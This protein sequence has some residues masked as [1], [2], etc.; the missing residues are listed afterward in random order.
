MHAVISPSQLSGK[1]RVPPSKSASHRALICAALADGTSRIHN[2][3]QSKDILATVQAMKA[4]GAEFEFNGDSVVVTGIGG[5]TNVKNA[6]IY[7]NESGSTLRFIIPICCALGINAQYFGKGKL[8]SRPITPYLTEFV[9]HGVSFDYQGTMPFRTSGRLFGGKFYID[10]GISSQFITGLLL[11]LPLVNGE[12]EIHINGRL[13]SKPY[14]DI[15]IDVLKQFSIKVFQTEYGYKVSGGQRFKPCDFTVEADFSQAAFF[16]VASAL[17]GNKIECTGLNL[18]SVQGDK[19]II[20]ILRSCGAEIKADNSS[21]SV[22][23]DTLSPF[24]VSAADIPDLVPALCVLGA[25]CRGKSEISDIERLRIKESDR[26]ASS[27]ALVNSLGGKAYEQSG[28]IIIE[29]NGEKLSG[30]TI[31]SFNDHRIA[32]A[33][34][35]AACICRSD[36]II[37]NCE[38]VNKSY[39]CFYEDYNKIGGKANVVSM[40]Q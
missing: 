16:L 32:M 33:A 35:V 27:I 39:P 17:K 30:G 9:D 20:D 7:C 34:A 11:A 4:A 8:P 26:V 12:S 14:I 37:K 6:D 28:K 5:K 19:H 21:I 18:S 36:A 1:I 13:E 22:C 29:G 24:K 40:E 23:A 25:A 15:T 38:A 10:G 31:D 3:R 2:I